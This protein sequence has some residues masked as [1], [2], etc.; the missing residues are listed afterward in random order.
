M[1]SNRI[2][3]EFRCDRSAYS[4][5]VSTSSCR[6]IEASTKGTASVMNP[7]LL[8][9]LWIEVPPVVHAA[10]TCARTAGSILPGWW[11][12]PAVVTIFTP[13]ASIRQTSSISQ[14]WGM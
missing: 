3:G 7:G 13:A 4:W 10:S 5:M 14:A 12:T 2:A 11:K 9:V 1:T 6:W 8:P